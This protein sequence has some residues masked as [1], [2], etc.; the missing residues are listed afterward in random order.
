METSSSAFIARRKESET[1]SRKIVSVQ[2]VFDRLFLWLV[3]RINETLST[4]LP[5]N[6]FIGVLDI[7]GF[8]IFDVRRFLI[9]LTLSNCM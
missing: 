4:K 2:A 6:F 7:A 3:K 9:L 1:Y 5:R 8:E